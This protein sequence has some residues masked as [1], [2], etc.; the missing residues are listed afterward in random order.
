[1]LIESQVT[2][3]I[4]GSRT[5]ITMPALHQTPLYSRMSAKCYVPSET[6]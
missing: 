5:E 2:S 6:F 4:F 1:M 3:E